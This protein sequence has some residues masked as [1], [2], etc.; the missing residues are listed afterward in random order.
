MNASAQSTTRGST[1]VVV[2]AI[3]GMIIG[4]TLL[5]LAIGLDWS[6]FAGGFAIGV[7]IGMTG[8]GAYIWGYRNGMRRPR[9]QD[10]WLP[11]RDGAQ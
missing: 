9:V 11:S 6:G 1:S 5:I 3:V 2:L 8:V 4:L 7:G 10:A